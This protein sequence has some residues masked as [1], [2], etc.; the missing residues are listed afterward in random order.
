MTQG[1]D[2][3]IER[4]AIALFEAMLETPD[5]G[6]AAWLDRR[7]GD[8][9]ALLARVNAMRAADRAASLRT[10]GATADAAGDS[11]PPERLGA[12]RLGD[13]IG[14][15]GMGSVYR[16]TR[17]RGDFTHVAA[18]KIIKPGLLSGSLVDRFRRER[19][20]LAGL[21]HPNIAQLFDGGETDDGAPFIVMEYVDGVPLLEWVDAHAPGRARR[22]VLFE[23]ICRAVA[24]A[25]RNLVVHRDIT[26]SNVLVTPEGLVKLIDFGI[27]RPVEP[28]RA[29]DDL[30]GGTSLA[31]LSLTPGYA[32]PERMIGLEVT[33]AAD[34]YSLGKVLERLLGAERDS[35]LDAIVA[36]ATATDPVDRYPT[37]DALAADCAAWGGGQPVEAVNGG[38]RYRAAKFIGRNRAAIAA[39]VIG[40]ML[41][42][43]ALGA[44][45]W[46]Y[47]RAETARRD[48]EYRFEQTRSIA[49]SMMGEVYEELGTVPGS[50]KARELLARTSLTYLDALASDDDAP[51]DVRIEAARGYTRLSNVTGGG[52]SGQLGRF[53][54]AGALH[55]EAEKI[56]KPLY[57]RHP[58]L[59]E[60]R[61]AYAYLLLEQASA[62]LYVT[63]K[64]K[65]ARE[66]AQL[67]QRL[68]LPTAA[69]DKDDA[70][71]YVVSVQAEGDSWG[72]DDSYAKARV[73]HERAERWI[74]TLPAAIRNEPKFNTA[75]AANLRLLADANRELGDYERALPPVTKAAAIAQWLHASDPDNPSRRRTF[76]SANTAHARI[77]RALKRYPEARVAIGRAVAVARR[78][79]ADAP[80]DAGAIELAAMVIG[81]EA[82]ILAD[83]GAFADSFARGDESLAGY[84]EIARLGDNAPGAMR[85]IAVT[86]ST[87]GNN[88]HL[89]RDYAGACSRWMQSLALF[90][91][92][93]A[94][95]QLAGTDK[96]AGLDR[97]RDRV[98]RGC[99]NGPPRSVGPIK[100]DVA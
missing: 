7:A 9:P 18:V 30:E 26:P 89:G 47:I 16:A 95:G 53:K 68:L 85:E 75:R 15:G 81:T 41:L 87:T 36:R 34:I 93:H 62:N 20:T 71:R 99:R 64:P 72:W 28:T 39:S 45:S 49:K 84:R 12:Y 38:R 65:L 56:I 50:T 44:T 78:Q 14:R 76:I 54:D 55:V 6:R 52:Q 27:A 4:E 42:F 5:A 92:L 40:L 17:D 83:Q 31:S 90:E 82:Q 32:A 100:D 46:S 60:V 58:D 10:G 11:P 73:H 59:V 80:S 1:A 43:G 19:Q 3:G 21:S 29:A 74:E 37:V 8:R 61:R 69:T 22:L 35:E 66:Q 77:L 67:T 91:G 96:V 24:V 63:G 23:Q 79:Q 97:V 51:V 88:H 25:H 98:A 86:L 2:P 48:A 94:K 13:L 70:R 57:A 33:T